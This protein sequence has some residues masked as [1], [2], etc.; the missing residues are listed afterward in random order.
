MVRKTRKRGKASWGYHLLINAAKCDHE[1]IRS[2]DKIKGFTKEL[3]K[4]ID[5]KAFG[6]PRVVHFGDEHTGGY[7][8]VQLIHTSCITGHFVEETDDVYI[9][10]FSCK[11]FDPKIA[12]AV[13]REFFSPVKVQTTFLK[14]QA[15]L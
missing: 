6:A 14:R 10:I 9:D 1:A 11:T 13:F 12:V 3:V 7:S 8:L 2:S 4:R 15:H 5:M